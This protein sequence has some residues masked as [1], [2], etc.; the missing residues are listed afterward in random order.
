MLKR[1]GV[2][3]Q[4]HKHHV[5]LEERIMLAITQQDGTTDIAGFQLFA[6]ISHY[7]DTVHQGHYYLRVKQRIADYI[8][9]QTATVAGGG[10][11]VA[12]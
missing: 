2:Q 5:D 1:Y 9:L 7:G 6:L 11:L 3:H 4:K 12:Q 8:E 10:C